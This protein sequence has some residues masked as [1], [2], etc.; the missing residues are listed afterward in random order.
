M[1]TSRRTARRGWVFVSYAHEDDERVRR[2]VEYLTSRGIPVW[3]DDLLNPGDPWG[4]V[5]RQK[6]DCAAC[7]VVVWSRASVRSEF[8]ESE[9]RAALDHGARSGRVVPVLLD[10][11]ART[12]IPLPFNIYEYHDL[13]SWD[14]RARGP[15][16]TL[17]TVV[18]RLVK[19]PPPSEEQWGPNLDDDYSVPEAK[20]ASTQM[21]QLTRRLRSVGEI[22]LGDDAALENLRA[23]LEEVHKTLDVVDS[24]VEE[25]IDA[26]VTQNGID[27]R[28]YVRFER[29][30]L[31]RK[32][33]NG[34]GHCDLIALHYSRRGGVRTWLEANAT[35]RIIDR[36]DGIFERLSEADHDLFDSLGRI[37]DVLTNESRVVV[38]L[39][40]ADQ[41]EAARM[42]VADGRKRLAPLEA[43][44]QKSIEVLQEI[45]QS[46]GFV[47]D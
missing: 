4:Q 25:F 20:S 37:G 5:L 10:K 43:D 22:L 34:R 30:T 7:V 17:A 35:K 29:G 14:G 18:I 8:V 23:A 45:E 28:P 26:G 42:R 15:L 6:L 9:A 19:R 33:R 2:I 31:S 21:R 16:K 36:A 41:H 12:R 24:A 1:T 11:E 32:I 40:T 13:S 27:H 3:W 46:L 44:L 38:N 39:I 47:A